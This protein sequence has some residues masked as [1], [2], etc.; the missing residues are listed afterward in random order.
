[1]SEI[2]RVLMVSTGTQW[3]VGRQIAENECLLDPMLW[4]PQMTPDG[5]GIH[6]LIPLPIKALNLNPKTWGWGEPTEEIA[7]LYE[8]TVTLKDSRIVAPRRGTKLIES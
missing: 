3:V 6:I 4:L 2:D 7:K 5:Q 8:Q 1:M